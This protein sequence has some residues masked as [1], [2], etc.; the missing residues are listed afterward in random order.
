MAKFLNFKTQLTKE[1]LGFFEGRDEIKKN[2]GTLN[3]KFMKEGGDFPYCDFPKL[4]V[5]KDGRCI[6][7]GRYSSMR[8]SPL[9]R[10]LRW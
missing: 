2:L 9:R 8:S 6:W 4:W 7:V 1:G 10:S 5:G 3:G